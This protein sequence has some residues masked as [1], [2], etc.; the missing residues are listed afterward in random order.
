MVLAPP[1]YHVTHKKLPLAALA[2][3]SMTPDLYRLFTSSDMALTHHWSSLFSYNLF[4]GSLLCL[5]WYMLYRPV[6]YIL[7]NLSHPL[8]FHTKKQIIHFIALTAIAVIC[9]AATHLL[10]DGITHLDYRTF[11]FHD[12][13]AQQIQWGS[14]NW[15]MH[16]ILQI[17]FSIISLPILLWMTYLYFKRHHAPK[18]R[19]HW[20]KYFMWGLFSLSIM[21]GVLGYLSFASSV[22]PNLIHTDPYYYL[23]R[24]LN[25]F[26]RYFLLIFSLGCLIFQY[27]QKYTAYNSNCLLIKESK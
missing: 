24:S 20:I 12:F 16:L 4:F 11:A 13:L 8:K 23:G 14:H 9:G 2:M 3:G 25:Y 17:A 1:I 6:L 21:S 7:F 10:W 19:P 5:I 15:P 27:I 26:F 22:L 18:I